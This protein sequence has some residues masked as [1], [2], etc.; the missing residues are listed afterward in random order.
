M[1]PHPDMQGASGTPDFSVALLP[2]TALPVPPYL[3]LVDLTG[4][5]QSPHSLLRGH[6]AGH[7]LTVAT[8][9]GSGQQDVSRGDVCHG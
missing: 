2:N 9:W 1:M 8:K 5:H 7:F 3:V 4:A 6:V